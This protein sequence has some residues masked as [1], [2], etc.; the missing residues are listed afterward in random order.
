MGLLAL[1][2]AEE[3]AEAD[4]DIKDCEDTNSEV[5]KGREGGPMTSLYCPVSVGGRVELTTK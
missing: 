2:R 4:V 3:E 1:G 5:E